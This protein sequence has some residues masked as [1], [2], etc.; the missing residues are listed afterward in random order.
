MAVNVTNPSAGGVVTTP[1]GGALVDAPTAAGSAI[2]AHSA[3][4]IPAG[5]P[6]ENGK[7]AYE[8]AVEDGYVGT[9]EEWL[10]SL[11]GPQGPSGTE[12]D[13]PNLTV[14]FENGLI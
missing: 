7:S 2:P 9:E 13:L 1:G 14:T 5:K 10:A 3:V 11:V 8:L 6:G 12:P 4:A